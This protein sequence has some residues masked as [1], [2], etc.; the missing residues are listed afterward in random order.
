MRPV[1]LYT[2][3]ME[4]ITII[5]LP[6]EAWAYL[7]HHGFYRIAVPLMPACT[8]FDRSLPV[9]KFDIQTV[10]IRAERFVHH[11]ANTMLLFTDDEESALLLKAA[12]LPGQQ[13]ALNEHCRNAMAN[14]FLKALQMLRD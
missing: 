5:A 4:P 6:E 8:P 2:R 3:Q 11:C 10:S 7:R 13:H 12:F 14:G 1:V 9:P